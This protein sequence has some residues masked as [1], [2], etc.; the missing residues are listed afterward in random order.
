M[1]WPCSPR[2]KGNISQ[3]LSWVILQHIGTGLLTE[4]RE[5]FVFYLRFFT[6]K[7]DDLSWI[8]FGVVPHRTADQLT[9]ISS[10]AKILSHFTGFIS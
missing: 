7:S 8:V 2:H 5:Q 1:L 10:A 3:E 9:F 6:P 4:L